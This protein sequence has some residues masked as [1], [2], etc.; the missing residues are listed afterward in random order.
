MDSLDDLRLLLAR[1]PELWEPDNLLLL[2][3]FLPHDG[4]HKG[5][6]RLEFLGGELLYSMRVLAHGQ[7]VWRWWPCL[8]LCLC[9]SLPSCSMPFF[10]ASAVW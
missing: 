4:D 9:A 7:C 5:T 10:S 2:Q 6:V 3:E 8:C 1:R